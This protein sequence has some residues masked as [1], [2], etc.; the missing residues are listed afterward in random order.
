MDLEG[1]KM[2]PSEFLVMHLLDW[3]FPFR[4]I[5]LWLSQNNK[6]KNFIIGDLRSHYNGFHSALCRLGINGAQQLICRCQ[7]LL[8]LKV[9]VTKTHIFPWFRFNFIKMSFKKAEER[10]K[11]W[12]Y[13]FC[14][15]IRLTISV[16]L[17]VKVMKK[18]FLILMNIH[19]LAQNLWFFDTFWDL[20]SFRCIL[21]CEWPVVVRL[22]T[23]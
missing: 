11:N 18:F 9:R 16:K 12:S 17:D 2:I 8:A 3:T 6:R 10:F 4:K 13:D 1:K 22:L 20:D 7:P 23:F 19:F 5:T 21:T 14:S 15:G